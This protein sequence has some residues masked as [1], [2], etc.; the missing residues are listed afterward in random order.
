MLIPSSRRANPPSGSRVET[1]RHARN[2]RRLALVRK[3][4][5]Q[6]K[7]ARRACLLSPP[8]RSMDLSA[9]ATE[10]QRC[11]ALIGSSAITMRPL[12]AGTSPE[13]WR[14]WT[15]APNGR[16]WPVS[17]GR[18]LCRRGRHQRRCVPGLAAGLGG[19]QGRDRAPD[20]RRRQRGRRRSI[21]SDPPSQRQVVPKR[22]CTRMD[23]RGRQDPPFRA[24][25]RHLAG[26]RATR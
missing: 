6:H 15:N 1:C 26:G 19:L 22:V 12:A 20:R 23:G 17:A 9:P 25:L 11:A 18:H 14:T 16:K 24:V 13:C 4:R 3:G 2:P 8:A 7:S 10:R 21:C 5:G